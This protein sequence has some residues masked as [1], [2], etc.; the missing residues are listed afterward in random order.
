MFCFQQSSIL[1]AL[2]ALTAVSFALPKP[3][4]DGVDWSA[5]TANV[6]WS[7]VD[8]G[9]HNPTVTTV[10]KTAP[11]APTPVVVQQPA[12]TSKVVKIAVS[13]PSSKPASSSGSSGSTVSSSSSKRGL[14]YNYESPSL[15]IFTSSLNIGWGWNWSGNRGNLP[16]KFEFVPMCWGP[17]KA[18][19]FH[20]DM[21]S[22]SGVSH[23]LSF[24]EP[25]IGG[26]ANLDVGS[27]VAGHIEHLNR[28]ASDKTKIG[29]VSVSNGHSDAKTMGLDFLKQFL[30]QCSK[31]A[32]PCKV[33]F[34]PVHW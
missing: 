26:Q 16:S 6:D 34:C 11:Q 10:V 1:F 29:A 2:S 18:D 5:A 12:T 25:D 17:G 27:A 32:E 9:N 7:N 23:I 19:T 33:D 14:A 28:Y 4:Y 24:N 15:D 31:Q 3:Q 30:D 8:Y 13:T 22:N 20:K 21:K